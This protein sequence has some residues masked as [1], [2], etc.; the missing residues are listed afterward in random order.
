VAFRRPALLAEN[1]KKGSRGSVISVVVQA[2]FPCR[3]YKYR[4]SWNG[5]DVPLS[6]SPVKGASMRQVL[7]AL[8]LAGLLALA[9][10]ADARDEK[11]ESAKLKPGDPAPKLEA[12]KWLQGKEVKEFKSGKVYVV[13]FWATWCGPCIVMMPHM[14]QLQREFKDK[15]VTF[16]GFTSKDPGNTE[17]K[18]VEFVKKRGPKLGYTFAW[19]DNRDTNDA[20]MK[21]SGQN[22]IPCSFVVDGKGKIAWIGH[23]MYLDAVLPDVVAGKWD[24]KKGPEELE[25]IEKDVNKVFG[26]LGGTDAEA[27]LKTLDEFETKHPRLA[28]I[29][30]FVGPKISLLIRA[31]KDAEAKKIAEKVI[32]SATKNGDSMMLRQISGALRS[33]KAKDKQE[34]LKL[35]LE[36]AKRMLK[37]EGEKD[38]IAL[39]FVAA[40]YN[41]T[42]DKDKAVEYC[43]KAIENAEDARL[44]KQLEAELKK[45]DKTKEEK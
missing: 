25:K 36:A 34:Y 7:M 23:P 42:G 18:V 35:S 41:A 11:K 1:R 13:E 6:F 14:G 26:A 8:T 22:G 15:D 4:E 31:G 32:E 37:M 43:R 28:H 30:Y 44:K 29:P 33:G 17:D 12:T 45:F 24:I 10:R 2:E 16:I 9:G 5:E 3:A 19:A 40:S 21:A 27:S 20:W 39:Y 38:P